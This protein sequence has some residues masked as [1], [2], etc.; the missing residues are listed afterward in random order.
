MM[1]AGHGVGRGAEGCALCA[2]AATAAGGAIA[3]AIRGPE[4]F[5]GCV[6]GAEACIAPLVGASYDAVQDNGTKRGEV[7]AGGELRAAP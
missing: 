3:V 4:A 2:A 7:A 5:A 1:R 6:R